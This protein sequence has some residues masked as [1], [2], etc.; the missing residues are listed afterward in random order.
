MRLERPADPAACPAPSDCGRRRR[1][2][3]PCPRTPLAAERASARSRDRVA[4]LIAAT[5]LRHRRASL[6]ARARPRRRRGS[7]AQAIVDEGLASSDGIARDRSR[8][9]TTSRSSTSRPT[10]VSPDA[11]R[12]SRCTCSSASCA[13]P[14]A[15]EDDELLVAIADPANVHGID[16]LRLATRHQVELG[17]ASRDD[18]ETEIKPPRARRP[19]PSARARC[20]SD[21]DRGRRAR[22][23]RGR[24]R[25]RGRRRHLRRAARPARQLDHL[26]GRRGRGQRH[27]LRAAGGRADRPPPHRRRPARGA[28][29]PEADGGRRHD[30][31]EGAREARHRRAPQAAG[32]PHLAERRRRRPPARHPRRDAADGRRRG[33]RH[34]PARQ[35]EAGA[36]ARGARPLGGDAD[37]ARARSSRRPDRRA[38]R[39][40]ADRLR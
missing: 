5:G 31:P 8:A 21:V 11:P 14:Y 6:A 24:G 23:R 9:A 3:R 22:R 40:R 36:D 39:H 10:G 2:R 7:V 17:V 33:R 30:A 20:S 35:V 19:R 29:H 15:V 26:P 13:L 1:R 4:D 32:R 16:E 18:I 12:S 28:A 27:P 37:A 25:P 34:A 38:A